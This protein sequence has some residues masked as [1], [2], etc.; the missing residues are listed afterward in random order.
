MRPKK[1]ERVTDKG[2]AVEEY[3]N[4]VYGYNQSNDGWEAHLPSEAEILRIIQKD[5]HNKDFKSF[6]SVKA[7]TERIAKAIKERL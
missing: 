7:Y 1:K 5:T 3:N 2:T 6:G 4:Y